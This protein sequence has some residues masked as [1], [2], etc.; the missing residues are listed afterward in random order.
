GGGGHSGPVQWAGRGP[1]QRRTAPAASSRTVRP[2]SPTA[3]NVQ[4]GT[5]VRA[6]FPPVTCGS[7]HSALSSRECLLTEGSPPPPSGST[8]PVA[9][10]PP[11][12]CS[13]TP[14]SG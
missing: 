5:A 9:S 7:S 11:P 14:S 3:R 13:R 2:H 4:H 1:G 6:Q 12:G 10:P 8:P